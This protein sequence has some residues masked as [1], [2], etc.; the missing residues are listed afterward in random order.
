[1]RSIAGTTPCSKQPTPRPIAIQ[2]ALLTNTIM[3]KRNR[4]YTS[5]S[6]SLKP[7]GPISRRS[8]RGLPL[9]MMMQT[10]YFRQGDH[11]AGFRGLDS[12]AMGAIHCQGKMRAKAVIVG[13]IGRE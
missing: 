1:A 9:I 7:D 2:I 13:D 12:S 6:L 4:E 5:F 8:S 10:A 3:R 11:S